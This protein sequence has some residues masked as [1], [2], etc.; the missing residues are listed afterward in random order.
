VLRRPVGSSRRYGS[1][2]LRWIV[3]T[4]RLI[5]AVFS[6]VLT[7][8]ALFLVA[9][10]IGGD[11]TARQVVVGAVGLLGL[12][13][14]VAAFMFVLLGPEVL[15]KKVPDDTPPRSDAANLHRNIRT[16]AHP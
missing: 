16:R 6:A 4:L 5:A 2:P 10:W 14:G 12:A 15:T 9:D 11:S 7:F 3:A 1:R 8:V 13:G